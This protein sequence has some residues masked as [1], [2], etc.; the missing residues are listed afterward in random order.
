MARKLN[1]RQK[2]FLNLLF[3][4]AKGVVHVAKKGAGYSDKYHTYLI[5]NALH[6]EITD[7]ASTAIAQHAPAAVEALGH[8]LQEGASAP[9]AN[10]RVTVAQTILDRVG[11]AKKEKLDVNIESQQGIFV[12]PAKRQ[13]DE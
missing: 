4:E 12:L 7:M 8:A 1:A 11:I 10:I 2:K 13:R 5:I 3:G 9:G 6:K